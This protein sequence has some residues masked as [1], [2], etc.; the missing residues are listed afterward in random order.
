MLRY[1]ALAFL[2]VL[3]LSSIFVGSVDIDFKE[4]FLSGTLSSNV[5]FNLRIPRYILAFFMGVL[6]SLS[7]WLYQGLFRNSLMTPFTLGISGGAVLGVG[8]SVVLGLE[9]ALFGLSLSA[10]FGFIGA[11]SSVLLLLYFSRFVKDTTGNSLL[12]L[13]IALSFFFSASLMVLF[14]ISSA[15]QS[16]S[17][18]RYTMGDLSTIG[19]KESIVVALSSFILFIFLYLKRYELAMLSVSEQNAKL[20]GLDT[21]KVTLQLLIISSFVIGVAISIT[22]PIGFVGLI[23]PH[24]AKKLFNLPSYKLLIPSA[25]LGGLFLSACDTLSRLS[26]F[27]SEIPIGVVT[28]FVGGPFFIY[29]ILKRV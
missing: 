29:L 3:S 5:F 27:E 18:L 4:I 11:M 6:L 15:T 24:M 22:G 26:I 10:L 2:L 12:L 17:I 8:I 19:Y 23:I 7:G 25:L 16:Y 14:S 1:L 21:K 9:E 28:A 20:K 13:G